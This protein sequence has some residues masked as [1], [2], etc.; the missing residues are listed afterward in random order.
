[1]VL[2]AGCAVA[3]GAWQGGH[4][5]DADTAARSPEGERGEKSTDVQTLKSSF[6]SL[7]AD[8]VAGTGH[9]R[10]SG[11]APLA[12][13]ITA[14]GNAIFRQ[15]AAEDGNVVV[16][17][18]SI[19]VALAMAA[20]GST[21]GSETQTQMRSALKHHLVGEEDE[22][23]AWFQ[24]VMPALKGA[25]PKVQLLIANSLWAAAD[26]KGKYSE[27][28][29]NVFL[30]EVHPLGSAAQIN[31]WVSEKTQAKIPTLLNANPVGPAVLLNAV[32]FKGE[33]SSKIDQSLTQPGT[34]ED[35]EGGGSKPC[36]YMFR[37]EKK[38]LAGET[39]EVQLVMLPYGEEARVG[40]FVALPKTKGKAGMRAAVTELFGSDSSWEDAVDRMGRRPVKLWL[41]RFKVEY[42]AKSL[43]QVLNALGMTHAFGGSAEFVRMTDSQTYI[44]DVLH[45]ALI[46]VCVCVFCVC[47]CV[48]VFLCVCVCLCVC[49]CVCVCVFV[50]V[51]IYILCACVCLCVYVLI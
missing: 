43:K 21:Q 14:A 25:D 10:M 9:D 38:V 44:E 28:C 36:H 31:A 6:S 48:C 12:S 29:K 49:L 7:P 35:L 42:G 17:P 22:L 37:A 34:F 45:K 51:Y 40:A 24:K 19:S 27:V 33:W 16:S 23:H 13:P 50:C 26:V 46:E 20:A 30:S 5:D 2:F 41:P 4:F 39:D 1:M 3:W 32:Y 11:Q 18:V 8:P 15:L 47:V